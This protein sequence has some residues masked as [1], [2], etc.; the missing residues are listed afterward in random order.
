MPFNYIQTAKMYLTQIGMSIV[1]SIGAIFGIISLEDI[2]IIISIIGA[3]GT[4]I[5]MPWYFGWKKHRRKEKEAREIH[6]QKQL[7]TRN[8]HVLTV[9]KDLIELGEI[10]KSLSLEEKTRIAEE[11]IEQSKI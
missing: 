10:D 2:P 6:A 8:T 3:L 7:E 1:A 11:Y 4:V 5:A 9:I